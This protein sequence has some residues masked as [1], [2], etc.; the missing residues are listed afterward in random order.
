MNIFKEM[1]C[2]VAKVSAYPKFLQNRKGKVFGYGMLLSTLFFVIAYLIPL[3]AFMVRIGGI[4]DVLEEHVPDFRLSKGTLWIEETYCFDTGSEYLDIDTEWS[5]DVDEASEFAE[6]Y[7]T[8]VVLDAEKVFLKNGGEIQLFYY[9]DLGELEI[10]KADLLSFVPV[11]YGILLAVYVF[12][13][14][15]V[16]GFFFFGVIFA[17]LLGLILGSILRVH[18]TFGETYVL[19]IY[20]RTLSLAIKAVVRLA[21][22]TIPMFGV[23]NFGI[24]LL[25][26]FLALKQVKKA[27]AE[28]DVFAWAEEQNDYSQGF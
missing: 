14:L 13:Y 23:I 5:F 25:Y 26:L 4:A 17:A 2:S 20:S 3:A 19:A 8:V 9:S 7:S 27:W 6:D 22:L 24:S 1:G 28:Q 18:L 21:G 11:M 10:S 12:L 16:V 15:G